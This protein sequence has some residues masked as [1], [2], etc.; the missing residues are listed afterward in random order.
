[1]LEDGQRGLPLV[2]ARQNLSAEVVTGTRQ[3]NLQSWLSLLRR[4][5]KKEGRGTS[6]SH[7]LIVVPGNMLKHPPTSTL[8][9]ARWFLN[10]VSLPESIARDLTGPASASASAPQSLGL[11]GAA[12]ADESAPTRPEPASR[13]A[14]SAPSLMRAL[15]EASAP[16][17]Y[18]ESDIGA[19]S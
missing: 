19:V 2:H 16:G 8:E 5:G 14:P 7:R 3:R 10:L 15:L 13:A 4:P 12:G 11:A 6:V 18:C 17:V 9:A 1:M